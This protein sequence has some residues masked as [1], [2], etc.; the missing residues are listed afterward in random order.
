VN[1]GGLLNSEQNDKRCDTTADAPEIIGAGY[2]KLKL[3]NKKYFNN[4]Y[5]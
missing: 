3:A 2:E 4:R 1:R 5:E